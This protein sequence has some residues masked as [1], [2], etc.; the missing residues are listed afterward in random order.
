LCG[1]QFEVPLDSFR[2]QRRKSEPVDAKKGVSS[3]VLTT[4][5]AVTT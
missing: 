2:N 5:T 1:G 4:V 3:N